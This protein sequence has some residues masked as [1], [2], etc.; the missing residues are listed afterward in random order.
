VVKGGLMARKRKGEKTRTRTDIHPDIKEALLTGHIWRLLLD[1]ETAPTWYTDKDIHDLWIKYG[2]FILE[3]YRD[4]GTDFRV[5]PR[6]PNEKGF[7]SGCRPFGWWKY[8]NKHGDREKDE[9]EFD[10]LRRNDLL[11]PGEESRY[12]KDLEKY[13]KW[14]VGNF[15]DIEKE[16]N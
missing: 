7:P 15:K 5:Y 11:F 14:R 12:L 10:F 4:I 3:D 13:K 16:N 9:S 1:G 2:D 8:N 6:R